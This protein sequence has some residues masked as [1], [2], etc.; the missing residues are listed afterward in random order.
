MTSIANDKLNLIESFAVKRVRD[1]D[2]SILKSMTGPVIDGVEQRQIIDNFISE[3]YIED[4]RNGSLASFVMMSPTNI[5]L[6]FFSLRCGELFEETSIEKMK[7]GHNA[8][9]ALYKLSYNKINTEKEYNDALERIRLANSEGLTVEDFELLDDKKNDW[10]YDDIIDANKEIN[11]VLKVHSAVELK[12]FG[13]NQS[14]KAYWKSLGLPDDKKMG[15]CL[16]FIKIVET[17]QTMLNSVGCQYLYLF[18]ADQETEG[19][20]VQYYRVRLGFDSNA[21]MTA[22]KPRFDWNCQFLFQD[23]DN[24]FKRREY[25]LLSLKE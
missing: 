19:Q 4:D 1:L 5:P 14:S 20:L 24:L 2:A 15:E 12:L 8:Y 23:M 7:I 22:N 25:F 9:I 11:K 3:R 10:K 13:T 17:I 18:A 6:A 21:K 16:F